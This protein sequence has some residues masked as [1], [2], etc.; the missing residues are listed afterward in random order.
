[1]KLAGNIA[2]MGEIRNATKIYSEKLKVSSPES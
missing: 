2:S 1:M